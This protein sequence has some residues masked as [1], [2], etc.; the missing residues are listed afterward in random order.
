[1]VLGIGYT[2]GVVLEALLH[3]W[4]LTSKICDLLDYLA[5]F[6][7]FA[8]FEGNQQNSKTLNIFFTLVLVLFLTL[9]KTFKPE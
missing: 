3:T 4:M 2:L 8:Y 7:I 5:F 9:K 1:M 6:F